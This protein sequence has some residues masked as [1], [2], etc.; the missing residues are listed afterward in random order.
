MV[1]NI[2]NELT[3]TECSSERCREIL[4]AIKNDIIG[5]G[6]IDFNKIIPQPEG[7]YMGDLGPEEMKLYRDNNWY[8]WRLKNWGTKWNSYGYEDG[9]WYDEE[10]NQIAFLSANYSALKIIQALSRIY[11]DVLFKL[12]YADEIIGYTVGEISFAAGEDINGRVLQ[13]CTYEAQLLAADILG[14][15][16]KFDI[17]EGSGFVP[18]LQGDHYDYCSGVYA[19]ESF[20]CDAFFGHPVVLCYDEDHSKVWLE[21]E[22]EESLANAEKSTLSWGVHPCR[23]WDEFNEYLK[24]L[25]DEAY[26]TACYEEDGSMELC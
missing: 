25:G 15:D 13:D 7:L 1:N 12:R 26:R 20:Q 22:N 4:E 8:D 23:S 9:I 5:I 2:I 18:S 24:E 19:S 16:L 3:F 17:A 11:P 14:V 10:K 6:S 21:Y